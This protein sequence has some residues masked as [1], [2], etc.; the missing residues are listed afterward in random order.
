MPEISVVIPSFNRPELLERAVKSVLNQTFH[1]VE[2]IVVDDASG[3]G[4]IL[5]RVEKY[6]NVKYLRN[7]TNR[8][9]C[10]SRNRGISEAKGRYINFLDDDDILFP[11]KLEKQLYCFKNNRDPSLGMVTC[12]A[13]DERSGT[14]IVKQNKVKGDVHRKLLEKF[15]VSGIETML[16]KTEYVKE[17][18]GFDEKL[19]SSHEYD[20]LI[21]FTEKYTVDYVDEVLTKEFRSI[22]QIS[23]NFD[24]KIH[25][26][27][28]L[29]KKH[30]ERFKSV[31]ILFWLK[32]KLKLW[33]LL[34]R[35]YVGKIFGEKFYRKLL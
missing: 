4:D 17:I 29:Y 22:N 11:E 24:K 13:N 19:Q 32:M 27:K 6:S 3:E 8:G 28:Y 1:D 26:A 20:L 2:I 31:G 18:G 23:T 25:G 15:A 9:A 14:L 12:H 30:D 35:Y 33:F 7:E 16:F 5:S 34:F 10:Y 21:R